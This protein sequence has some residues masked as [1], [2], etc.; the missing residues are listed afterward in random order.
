MTSGMVREKK[1]KTF[2]FGFKA[3]YIL[4]LHNHYFT[5]Q[6]RKVRGPLSIKQ[7]PNK[8]HTKDSRI[9]MCEKIAQGSKHIA[10]CLL[11]QGV[12][13]F[14]FHLILNSYHHSVRGEK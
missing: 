12:T 2:A 1:P 11:L 14:V 6:K 7:T 5:A 3:A 10:P 8:S 9:Q 13:R 4:V